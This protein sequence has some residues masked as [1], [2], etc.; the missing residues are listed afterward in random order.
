M[1]LALPSQRLQHPRLPRISAAPQFCSQHSPAFFPEPKTWKALRVLPLFGESCSSLFCSLGK[2]TQPL[3]LS[4]HSDLRNTSQTIPSSLG[5]PAASNTSFPR[6]PHKSWQATNH[7]PI[8]P[9]PDRAGTPRGME[10]TVEPI[11]PMSDPKAAVG[12]AAGG[13]GRQIPWVIFGLVCCQR[14][15]LQRQPPIGAR[16]SRMDLPFSQWERCLLHFPA[17]TH[18]SPRASPSARQPLGWILAAGK[19]LAKQ[20]TSAPL[21]LSCNVLQHPALLGTGHCHQSGEGHR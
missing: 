18:F 17:S 7:N 3:N 8:L 6:A 19:P 11:T 2:S 20:T 14:G 21:L 1:Q 15:V 10:G 13:L 9:Q 12:G 16:A 5:R 4:S